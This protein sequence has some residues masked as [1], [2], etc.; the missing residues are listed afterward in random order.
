MK[1]YLITVPG[2]GVNLILVA[3]EYISAWCRTH[4]IKYRHG[5][6]RDIEIIMDN[7]DLVAFKL[8]FGDC[9]IETTEE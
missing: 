5:G 6:L 9:L 2:K 1:T 4:S 3:R 7:L 8:K